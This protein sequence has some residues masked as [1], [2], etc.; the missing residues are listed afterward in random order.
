MDCNILRIDKDST[1]KKVITEIYE[2]GTHV[3]YDGALLHRDTL[4]THQSIEDL[5]AKAED[6]AGWNKFVKTL[7]TG[8]SSTPK[9]GKMRSLD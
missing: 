2:K 3:Q 9:R 5:I 6:R 4:P 1:I 8:D 7:V